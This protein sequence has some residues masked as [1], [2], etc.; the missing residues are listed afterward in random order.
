MLWP[1]WGFNS[2]RCCCTRGWIIGQKNFAHTRSTTNTTFLCIVHTSCHLQLNWFDRFI[3]GCAY[4]QVF[5]LCGGPFCFC[6]WCS[7]FSGRI[8]KPILWLI[9]HTLIDGNPSMCNCAREAKLCVWFVYM[10]QRQPSN[11]GKEEAH[12]FIYASCHARFTPSMNSFICKVW[13]APAMMPSNPEECL[14]GLKE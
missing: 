13:S 2:Q 3:Q 1:R 10:Q 5:K 7:T 14:L 12:I 8:L 9:K 11:G 4:M 6:G